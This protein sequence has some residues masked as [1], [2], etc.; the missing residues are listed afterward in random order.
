MR[1]IA[2]HFSVSLNSA[3]YFM[4][5]H[6]IQRRT[7]IDARKLAFLRQPQSFNLKQNLTVA[8][9]RLKLIG[10]VL[11]WCEGYRT[12]KSHGID[13]AN[14][15]PAAVRLFSDFLRIICGVDPKRLK[16]YLYCYS[17]Q[18]PEKLLT[19]WSEVSGIPKSQFTRPYI[20]HDFKMDKIG[21][22]PYGLVHIRYHDIKLL[23]VIMEWIRELK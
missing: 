22:M 1:E 20:R 15:D 10:T 14:S 2:K 6:D 17:N 5:H 4:R 11:Y 16:G 9:Q 13:F 8:E 19:Y 18:R 23:A 21:K 12:E 3:V 7:K